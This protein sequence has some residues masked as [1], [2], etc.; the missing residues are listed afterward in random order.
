MPPGDEE[1]RLTLEDVPA[2][3]GGKDDDRRGC[4]VGLIHVVLLDVTEKWLSRRR[5]TRQP[6][7]L[8]L[9]ER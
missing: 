5:T 6:S 2:A 1:V 7:S 3:D 4:V 8:S 9:N